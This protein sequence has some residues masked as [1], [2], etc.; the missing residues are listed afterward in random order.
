MGALFF[1]AINQT[2]LNFMGTVTV[3][4]DERP[5]FLREQANKVY[6]VFPYYITKVMVDMPPMIIVPM[7]LSLITYWG[8]G[9]ENTAEQFFKFY[10]ISF[11][12]G[13]TSTSYA[14]VLSAAIPNP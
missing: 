4:S 14:Y 6:S 11:L 1:F 13:F 3:F 12:L 7:I 9:F 5:V 10:L 8:V 2:M